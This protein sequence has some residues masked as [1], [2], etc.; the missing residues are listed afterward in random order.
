MKTLHHDTPGGSVQP[1]M[2]EAQETPVPEG[3]EQRLSALVDRL[4]AEEEQQLRRKRRNLR[5]SVFAMAAVFVAVA[6][7][8]LA[9]RH[10]ARIVEVDDP[11]EARIQTERALT[12]LATTFNKGVEGM[13]EAER[14]TSQVMGVLER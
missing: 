11:E 12:M 14:R 2:A 7:V 1:T 8:V 10:T 3:L 13:E 5:A 4:A 6:F 9:P